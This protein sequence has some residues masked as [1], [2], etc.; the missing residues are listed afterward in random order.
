VFDKKISTPIVDK[1]F[2]GRQDFT[3]SDQYFTF[4]KE[5]MRS[6]SKIAY[7]YAFPQMARFFKTDNPHKELMDEFYCESLL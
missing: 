4:V 5:K 7:F 1:F 6:Y 3:G 2:S